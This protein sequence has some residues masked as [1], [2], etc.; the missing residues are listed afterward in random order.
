MRQIRDAAGI[1]WMVYEVNPVSSEWRS[2]ESL[3]EG[4]RSG[5][6]C[7]ESSTEK[8]RLTPLPSGWENLPLD[9]LSGLLVTAAQVRR[10]KYGD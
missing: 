4:F 6:L 3:P 9:Q 2:I 10:V 1:E 7:F 5:W 8:R